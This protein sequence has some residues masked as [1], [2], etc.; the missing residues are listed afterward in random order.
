[1]H[2]IVIFI[3]SYLI[4]TSVLIT[5][6]YFLT[7]PNEEKK[8]F[9]VQAIV[10]AAIAVI[11][12]KIGSMVYNNPRPFVVGHFTPYFGHG[13][14]NGF[15]SDHTL[16]SSFLGFLVLFYNKKYGYLLLLFAVLIGL[17]RMKAGVH[18]GIDVLGSFVFAGIGAWL[19][20]LVA[21]KA[22]SWAKLK[23]SVSKK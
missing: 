13:T 2:G 20:S 9:V 19:G 17:A 1:M 23:P 16:L 7:L 18:H 10:G 22:L 5:G 12:A 15:P 3:A 14:D 8:R 21:N 4:F 11:L 6:Y